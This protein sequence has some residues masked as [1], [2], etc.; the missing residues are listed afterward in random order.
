[1]CDSGFISIIDAF[2]NPD[3]SQWTGSITYTL[4]YSTT[5]AGA[6]IVNAEQQFNVVNG[7]NLCLAPGLYRVVLQQNGFSYAITTQWGVP[8]SGGPYT[9]AEIQGNITLQP[10]GVLLART[11]L[12]QAQVLALNTPVTFVPAPGV[13]FAIQPQ[14]IVVTQTGT[15]TYITND[16]AFNF[17]IGSNDVAGIG[18]FR[19]VGDGGAAN[20]VQS[21]GSLDQ[22]YFFGNTNLYENLPLIGSTTTNPTGTGGNVIVA[23]YYTVVPLS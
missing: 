9:V 22:D 20:F 8:T 21:A 2:L 5:V 12:T 11:V 7:I 14:T 19:D 1:M 23:V 4:L 3:G 17:A 6:T 13:G 10:A 18:C 15:P 16:E